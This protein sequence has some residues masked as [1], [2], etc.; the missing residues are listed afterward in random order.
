MQKVSVFGTKRPRFLL[1]LAEELYF[2][3][4]S[5]LL[6]CPLRHHESGGDANGVLTSTLWPTTTH[7]P[8]ITPSN[9][10]HR[11]L[12]SEIRNPKSE[13]RTSN[14]EHRTSNVE[15][16][17]SNV[18]HRTSNIERRTS[19]IERRT[20]NVEHRTPNIEHRTSNI[21]HRMKARMATTGITHHASRIRS[22]A[23]GLAFFCQTAWCASSS[24]VVRTPSLL[25]SRLL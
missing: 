8:R 24:G 4:G 15:H 25:I 13:H 12:K 23:S 10:E 16:R 18:E 7:A 17:T 11:K 22:H 19:N 3:K 21:E 1:D 9:T 6:S 2:N 5:R 14:I 20:S